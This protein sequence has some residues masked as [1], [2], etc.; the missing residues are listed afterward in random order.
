MVSPAKG[1]A[2]VANSNVTKNEQCLWGRDVAVAIEPGPHGFLRSTSPRTFPALFNRCWLLRFWCC[3]H[4]YE[5]RRSYNTMNNT[6]CICSLDISADISAKSLLLAL[7][8]VLQALH[9]TSC[10]CDLGLHLLPGH[11]GRY[12]GEV[13]ALSCPSGSPRHVVQLRSWPA[14]GYQAKGREKV[15]CGTCFQ[16]IEFSCA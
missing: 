13:T 1:W 11:F 14:P 3:P 16:V 4:D 9:G 10:G 8:L 2:W 5:A 7:Y 12:F 15:D 6:A